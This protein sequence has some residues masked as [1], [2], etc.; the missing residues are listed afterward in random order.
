[1]IIVV[2]ITGIAISEKTVTIVGTVNEDYQIV[3]DDGDVYEVAYTE[4]GNEMVDKCVGKQVKATGV[5][6]ELEDMK[7]ISITSYE[8]IGE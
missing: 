4:K 6:E 3:V 2:F 5:V 7:T 8:V 1:M